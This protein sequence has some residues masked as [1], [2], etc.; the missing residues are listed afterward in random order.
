MIG[1]VFIGACVL[2]LMCVLTSFWIAD[3]ESLL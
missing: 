3:E 2:S 1:A